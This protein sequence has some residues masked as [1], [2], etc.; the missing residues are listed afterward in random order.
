MIKKLIILDPDAITA[1][2]VRVNI[3]TMNPETLG[4]AD[5]STVNVTIVR[6]Q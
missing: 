5:A 2:Y 4:D 6:E 3:S 1:K